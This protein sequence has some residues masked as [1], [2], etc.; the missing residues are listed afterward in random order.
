M[1]GNSCWMS[2]ILNLQRLRFWSVFLI[3]LTVLQF[4]SDYLF[5]KIWSEKQFSAFRILDIYLGIVTLLVFYVSYFQ[6][7]VKPG[8]VRFFHRFVVNFYIFSHLLWTACVAGIE[9]GSAIGLPTFLIG[10]FSAATLFIIP[11]PVFLIALLISIAGLSLTLMGMHVPF[12]SVVSQYYTAII[13]VA[14][15]FI[16]SRI[17]YIT[18]FR[19]Y[20]SNHE[21]EL[22]NTRLDTIVK[23]RTKELSTTNLLLKNE[24]EIRIRFEKELKKA[25]MRAEQADRLKTL[26]LAN[27]SH[28]IRTPLNGIL[29]FSDLLKNHTG[30]QG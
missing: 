26:F 14:V 28:E 1:P 2:C 20:V 15:A 21:L 8:E 24:I 6:R 4:G 25:L 12:T 23:E 11:S 22:V 29:G 7:P 3:F 19:N 16:T 18:R 10:M 5:V 27:M 30:G 13:L 17:L 9:A